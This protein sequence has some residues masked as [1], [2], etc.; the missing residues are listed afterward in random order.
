MCHQ[1]VK[2]L[3]DGVVGSSEV[4]LDNGVWDGDGPVI[5]FVSMW[6]MPQR[7]SMWSVKR[8]I[9]PRLRSDSTTVAN[10][11]AVT[12]VS[13]RNT[14]WLLSCLG[15]MAVISVHRRDRAVSSD[16]DRGRDDGGDD[17]VSGAAGREEG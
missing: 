1:L 4:W 10:A 2:A 15:L 8:A 14:S 6:M 16:I 3:G 12:D 5:V 17:D 11:D 7:M 9:M 13:G